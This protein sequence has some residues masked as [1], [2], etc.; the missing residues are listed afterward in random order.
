MLVVVSHAYS[1]FAGW[2]HHPDSLVIGVSSYYGIQL[3]YVLSGL[4]IGKLLIRELDRADLARTRGKRWR[5][6]M[7]RRWLRTLPAYYAWLLVLLVGWA[8]V[9]GLAGE[10]LWH[11]GVL[12]A[13]MLQNL[14][15]PMIQN[16]F[17]DVTWSLAVE[18][19]FYVVFSGLLFLFARFV[20]GNK[21]YWLAL[22]PLLV[23]PPIARYLLPTL[24]PSYHEVFF[25]PDC[26]AI[27]AAMAFVSCRFPAAFRRAAW[28][29]PVALVLAPLSVFGG[30][31]WLGAAPV[32][33]RM[34]GFDVVAFAMALFLPAASRWK[35]ARG[36]APAMVVSVARLSYCLYLTHLSVLVFMNYVRAQAKSN[37]SPIIDIAISLGLIVALSAALSF[38][39]E[40]PIMVRRPR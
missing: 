11:V 12:F 10:R 3:F 27:G 33:R 5:N 38:A 39:I 23:G 36:L 26:I 14:A 32:W 17:F 2:F 1:I 25:W 35:A 24:D 18:E 29:L 30:L 40:R 20:S 7:F 19:W 22:A 13:L 8:P 9:I 15:W 16:N 4:L 37:I 21:A 31:K 28:L 6:F 34:F